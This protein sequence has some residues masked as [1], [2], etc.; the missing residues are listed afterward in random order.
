MPSIFVNCDWGTSRF[1]LRAI[2]ATPW[3]LLS[4]YRS[5][6]GTASI[7]AHHPATERP[8][9]FEAIL[10]AGLTPLAA[11]PGQTLA[12]AP[13]L[14]S[15]MASSSI[16]WRELPYATLPQPINGAGLVWR[17]L[18][19]VRSVL[20][21]HRVLLISGIRGDA[22]ILRGEET[23]LIGIFASPG[24][25]SLT[26]DCLVIKPGT[27]SKHLRVRD[28]HLVDFQTYMTGELFAVLSEHSVLQHSVGEVAA[29]SGDPAFEA[30]FLTG[31]E[32]G[33]R[34]A[35]AAALF[36]VRTRQVLDSLPASANRAFLSGVL[37]GAELSGVRHTKG[38]PIVLAATEPM[39]TSYRRALE[40]LGLGNRL[41]AIPSEQVE[42]LSA[43]GQ[44][45]LLQQVVPTLTT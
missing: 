9:A 32:T 6:D 7:A 8:R 38:V 23:E 31:V 30:D 18:P 2:H 26:A 43:R 45:R 10:A 22:D 12:G 41:N 37:I 35:L 42:L 5:D 17:E 29:S 1:R 20:G 28:G 39:A 19:P 40:H 16:G 13:I 3:Q 44:A 15:G 34:F 33:C 27:H 14:V 11:E 36:R 4:E 25:T 21:E 24:F